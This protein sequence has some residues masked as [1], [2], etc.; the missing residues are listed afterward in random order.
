MK[1]IDHLAELER[2]AA[3]LN[4]EIAKLKAE[5]PAP[6]PLPPKDEGLRIVQLNNEVTAGLPD[7]K[8]TEK[9][10]AIVK[11]HSPW[12]Q[13][14]HDKF[15]EFRP[16]R[17]FSSAF[18]WVQ[19]VGRTER[20]NGKFALNFWCD[21]CRLWLR[22]RNSVGSDLDANALVL[23]CL[24]AGDVVYTPANPALGH[25][26]ELGLVEFGGKPANTDAWR[27]VMTS[28]TILT[29]SQPAQRRPPLS[30]VRIYGG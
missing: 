11:P 4:A 5:R 21:T 23:A 15:D 18:R 12:P 8:Q 25:V 10:F 30:N 22:S 17:A 16:L 14:L 6:P 28:G 3:K 26:W 7:L 24:A 2:Q 20:P 19:N 9:L 1:M 27:A 13:T 29:P